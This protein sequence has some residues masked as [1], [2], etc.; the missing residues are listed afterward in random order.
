MKWKDKE[1]QS[2]SLGEKQPQKIFVSDFVQMCVNC[3]VLKIM[4]IFKVQIIKGTSHGFKDTFKF[5][6]ITLM[7]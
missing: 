4:I 6:F 2:D 3:Y 1:N 5:F 7:C